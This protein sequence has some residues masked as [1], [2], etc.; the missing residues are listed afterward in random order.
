MKNSKTLFRYLVSSIQLRESREE[1]V[2][3]VYILMEHLFG[4]TRTQVLADVPLHVTS[5]QELA[6]QQVIERLNAAEP[7]QYVV[8]ESYFF[9]RRFMVNRAVLIPRPET[10]ELVREVVAAIHSQFSTPKIHILDIG[11]GSGCIPITL[12]LEIPG[13]NVMA[14]DV[15]DEALS[16][17]AQNAALLNAVVNF[18]KH[19]ILSASL[20][21]DSF[22][23]IVS[24]PPYI[25]NSEKTTMKQNVLDYEPHVALF[26]ADDDPLIFY[27]AIARQ[28]FRALKDTGLLAV[29]INERYSEEVAAIF[30]KEGFTAIKIIPDLSGKPRIVKGIK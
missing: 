24:N 27:K 3:M 18:V 30:L 15:S 8:G 17:A 13:A 11:T 14:I 7:I 19:D 12:A 20:P 28:A 6:M 26:V 9:G 16:V 29:E 22:H 2:S 25:G 23:V 10:E 5:D 21:E 1:I 4:L